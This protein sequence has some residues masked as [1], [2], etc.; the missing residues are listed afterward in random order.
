MIPITPMSRPFNDFEAL[1]ALY[2]GVAQI[3]DADFAGSLS[4]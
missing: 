3:S 1:S 2:G 4:S